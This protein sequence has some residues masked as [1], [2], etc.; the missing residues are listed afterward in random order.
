[1]GGFSKKVK[2]NTKKPTFLSLI[3]MFTCLKKPLQISSRRNSAQVSGQDYKK[4]PFHRAN[5]IAGFGEVR[6]LTNVEKIIIIIIIV[7]IISIIILND[8]FF[9]L[10]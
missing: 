6:P 4:L 9:F 2:L 8:N 7:I 1:M 10:T 5:Q 3:N